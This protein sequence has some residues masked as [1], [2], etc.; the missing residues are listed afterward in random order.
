MAFTDHLDLRTAV[1]EEVKRSDIVDVFPRLLKLAETDFNRKLRCREQVTSTTLVFT[2]GSATIPTD[3]Q[4]AIG[5]YDASGREYTQQ[6]LQLVKNPNAGAFYAL[7]ATSVYV[8]SADDSK[9]FEYYAKIAT[10]ADSLTDTN[11][12]LTKY[13]SLY[14]YAV[15]IE[16][17]KYLRDLEMVQQTRPLL[18][19][20]YADIQAQDFGERYSRASVRIQGVAP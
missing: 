15:T 12:L 10:I 9:L 3:F 2:S 18:D 6:T 13:P 8:D 5:L 4:E 1:I 14:L 19:M 7:N 16:A 11:W 20:E 17:A